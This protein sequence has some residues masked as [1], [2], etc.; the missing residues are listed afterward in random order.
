M[1][2]LWSFSKHHKVSFGHIISKDGVRIDPGSIE[3][4]KRIIL[5]NNKKFLQSILGMINFI[6]IF[7]PKFVE[8]IKPIFRLLK[9]DAH[10]EWCDEGWNGFKLIK[11]SITISPI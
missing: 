1:S 4:I 6:R 8:T 5:P 10:F 11:E 2:K 9:M 3:A 7:I